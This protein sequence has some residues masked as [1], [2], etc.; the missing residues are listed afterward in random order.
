MMNNDE[1]VDLLEKPIRRRS[2]LI[3]K[4][5]ECLPL[6]QAIGLAQTA[7]EFIIG[8]AAERHYDT[9]LQA[10]SAVASPSQERERQ[11]PSA[12]GAGPSPETATVP[13]P[14][15]T[16][17]PKE[18]RRRLID[19]FATGAENSK[20][21]AEF[22]LSPKQVQGVRMGCARAINKRR[23]ERENEQSAMRSHTVAAS[24]DDVVRYLRQQDDVV[25]PHK[26]GE[27]L[28]N[29]RFRL[30][31]ADLVSRANRM[32]ARQGKPGFDL[33]GV[34]SALTETLKSVNGQ[35]LFRI[36]TASSQPGS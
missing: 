19:R 8:T 10:K 22:G 9:A 12:S 32:R 31:L 6:D 27:F 34:Q 33:G 20:L 25:V 7:D 21:A 3:L 26:S 14:T 28:V 30:P 16:A 36:E 13:I 4:A 29:A 35:T 17:L 18:V 23:E 24:V 1:L 2:W 11:L 15:A 5:L